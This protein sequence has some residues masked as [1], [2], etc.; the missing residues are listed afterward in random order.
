MYWQLNPYAILILCGLVPLL[1]FAYRAYHQPPSLAGRLFL[2]CTIAAIGTLFT[3][4]LELLSANPQMLVLW[5][6]IR[7]IIGIFVPPMGLLFIV[8]YLGM[9]EWVNWTNVLLLSLVPIIRIFAV[10]TNDSYHLQWTDYTTRRMGNLVFTH[11]VDATSSPAFWAAQIYFLVIAALMAFVITTAIRRTPGILRGQIVYFLLAILLPSVGILLEIF[12]F[13][14]LPNLNF[15]VLTLCLAVLPLGFALFRY[16]LLDL[17]PAA[18]SFVL[19][20]MEDAVMVLD[21]HGRVVQANPAAIALRHSTPEA[22]IGHS[23]EKLFSDLP[24]LVERFD[25]VFDAREIIEVKG[26]DQTMRYFDLR[27]S[28]LRNTDK[29][30]TGRILVL[31]DVSA[32]KWAEQHELDLALERERT[33]LIKSFISDT[34]HDIMTPIS[35]MRISTYLLRALADKISLAVAEV[36]ASPHDAAE[37]FS[38]L[39][40][41]IN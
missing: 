27:I 40:T 39:E 22:M 6:Q 23:A 34:S 26:S 29:Q 41:T 31:R 21:L 33:Q 12:G 4:L 15:P 1:Y 3:Y 7:F 5:V 28:P 18:Q 8:A 10:V 2:A 17:V 13:N 11:Y 19:Q 36:K 35:A 24:H 37:A 20:S 32:T 25:K 9:D 14:P 38:T 16:R 30:T